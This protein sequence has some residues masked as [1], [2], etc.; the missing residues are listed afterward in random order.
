MG[1]FKFYND[2]NN[3]NFDNINYISESLTNWELY[4]ELKRILVNSIFKY[5]NV[6]LIVENTYDLFLEF[7]KKFA[8]R[9]ST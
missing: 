8:L 9:A 7:S 1:E 2:L 5:K 4:D 3:W 6:K